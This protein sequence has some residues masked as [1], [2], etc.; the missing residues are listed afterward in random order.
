MGPETPYTGE[1]KEGFLEKSD[2]WELTQQVDGE[3]RGK[4]E[5]PVQRPRGPAGPRH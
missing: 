1:G 2:E 3:V 5:Q 4:A